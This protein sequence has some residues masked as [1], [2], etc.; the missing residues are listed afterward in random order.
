MARKRVSLVSRRQPSHGVSRATAPEL[1][2]VLEVARLSPTQLTAIDR[3]YGA[4]AAD[5]LQAHPYRL[6]QEIPGIS[7]QTADTIARKL[8]TGK[9]NPA[10]PCA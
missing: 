9:A 4:R 2:T 1:R 10:R 8:G 7:F 5:A 6:V 3:R